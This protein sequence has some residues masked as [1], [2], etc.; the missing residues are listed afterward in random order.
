MD[1]V[2]VM[3]TDIQATA[4][5]VIQII[6]VEGIILLTMEV[7]IIHLITEEATTAV[8]TQIQTTITTDVAVLMDKGDRQ[9]QI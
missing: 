6:T 2:G 9:I 8:I 1:L 4:G 7:G 5:D 3:V